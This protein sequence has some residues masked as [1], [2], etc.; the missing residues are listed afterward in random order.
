MRRHRGLRPTEAFLSHASRDRALADALA[1]TLSRHGVP[2][3]YSSTNILG[4]QQWHDE[5]GSALAR[6]D[7][8][9]LLLS[10]NAVRSHWVKRELLFALNDHHYE[11]R[12]LPVLVHRCDWKRL[13]WTLGAL[14]MVTLDG[15]FESGCREILAAW[16]IG[17]DSSKCLRPRRWRKRP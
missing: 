11:N 3:W 17:F 15:D 2:V 4:A 16:G 9:V 10:P 6:C 1:A 13:S 12:I 14:Q 8:F 5:I 7:W